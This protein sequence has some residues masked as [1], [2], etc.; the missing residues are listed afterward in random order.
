[1]KKSV[2]ISIDGMKEL[3]EAFKQIP[4][5]AKEAYE[6]QLKI[7]SLDLQG[8]AQQLAP[9]DTGDL[10]GSAFT[11]TGKHGDISKKT[12]SDKNPESPRGELPNPED[13]EAYVGFSEP[14]ALRQH[15]DLELDH[16]VNGG[17]KGG[18]AH[19]LLQPLEENRDKY[20]DSF[21]KAIKKAVE[22]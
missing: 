3:Q 20:I 19:F 15:E 6:N 16:S 13:L 8:K 9:V 1:M 22:Q 18:Q 10:R 5:N 7:V 2:N 14:Y 11:V 21:G 4:D 12:Q 17:H